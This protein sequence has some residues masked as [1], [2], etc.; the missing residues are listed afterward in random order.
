[1]D[2]IKM[3]YFRLRKGVSQEELI[4]KVSKSCKMSQSTFDRRKKTPKEFRFGEIE[5]IVNILDLSPREI[6]E[7]LFPE[8]M[9]KR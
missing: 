5:A 9:A 4:R 7:M 3:D 1:M 8:R 6:V 2:V